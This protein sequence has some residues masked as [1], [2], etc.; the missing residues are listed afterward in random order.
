[1]SSKVFIDNSIYEFD[2]NKIYTI[3][4][5]CALNKIYLPCFCYHEKLTIAG[6]CRICLVQVNA[7]LVAS[8][9]VF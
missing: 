1:M 9:A 5:F 4:Q 7:S 8:R 6:N 3:F 2:S